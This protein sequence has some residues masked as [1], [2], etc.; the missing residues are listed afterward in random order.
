MASQTPPWNWNEKVVGEDGK[1][2]PTFLAWLQQQLTTTKLANDAVPSGR[3]VDTGTGLAGGGD[4]SV[5]RTLTLSA[6][7]DNLND[8]VIVSPA[9]GQLLKYDNASSSWKNV[10]VS[11]ALDV[12]SSTR[13]V[14]LYR[15][16]GGWAALPPGTAGQFLQTGGAGADPA[17]AS[18][19]GGGGATLLATVTTTL[20][21]TS[22]TLASS[23]SQSYRELYIEAVAGT[24]SSSTTN[25]DPWAVQFNADT[26]SHYKWV[27]EGFYPGGTFNVG[28]GSDTNIRT[29]CLASTGAAGIKPSHSKVS[30]PNYTQSTGP[31]YVYAEGAN[32]QGNVS[33]FRTTGCGIWVPTSFAA[34]TQIDVM[35]TGGS[36]FSTGSVFK[37]YGI[38]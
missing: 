37:L 21:Q 3:H 36:T 12:I 26:G 33:L 25:S 20:G 24:T 4:L 16:A 23:I 14:V 13:G 2:T 1:A 15:G 18:G 22:F 5:D 9:D 6:I 11:A 10:S 38:S 7:L 31:Q 35:T 17:W 19:G 8:V 34:I 29:A 27:I 32:Q 28:S 30:I